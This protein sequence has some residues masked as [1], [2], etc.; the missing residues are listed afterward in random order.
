[1]KQKMTFYAFAAKWVAA[2]ASRENNPFSASMPNP[3]EAF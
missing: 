3:A 1:M 2:L